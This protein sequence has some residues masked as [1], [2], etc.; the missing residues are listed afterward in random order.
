MGRDAADRARG[1]ILAAA[2]TP[3][4]TAAGR[5]PPE[6]IGVQS[7]CPDNDLDG[8]VDCST[9]CTPEDLSCGDCNDADPLVHP[10]AVESCNHRD[11]D[12]DGQVDPD[13]A[14]A[15][16]VA[17]VV[18]PNA[19]PNER[20]G[21]SV[22]GIGDVTDDLVPDLV[23]GRNYWN[24]GAPSNG[25]S[26][27]GAGPASAHR[28][29]GGE[30]QVAELLHGL[31]LFEV[32]PPEQLTDLDLPLLVGVGGVREALRPGDRLLARRRLDD[33]VPGHQPLVSA[34]GPSTKVRS[35]PE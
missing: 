14:R 10:G 23:V 20:F 4:E 2:T 30:V 32:V 6:S 35:F 22:V 28:P 8:Y 9:G 26:R 34:N 24:N 5:T 11:D 19:T 16:G 29:D 31:G 18:H 17:T 1:E 33:G 13:A 21:N 12:C 3:L 27:A 25:G 7:A 15:W